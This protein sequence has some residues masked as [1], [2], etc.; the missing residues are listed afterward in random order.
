MKKTYMTPQMEIELFVPNQAV[1]T[2][3]VDKNTSWAFDCMK[4]PNVDY[5]SN[6]INSTIASNCGTQVGYAGGVLTAKYRGGSS[7]SNHNSS[8]ATWTSEQSGSK[9]YLVVNYSSG[10]GL[11]YAESDNNGRN[12]SKGN[13]S[14]KSNY[15]V[16]EGASRMHAM[17]APVISTTS[18]SSSW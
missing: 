18:V 3:T 11:L 16:N 1:S 2:C 5:A 13:W 7:H 15:I 17:V 14:V 10:D 8:M 4:G 12:T 9:R 6:I